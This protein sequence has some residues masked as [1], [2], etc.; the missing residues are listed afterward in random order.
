MDVADTPFV[1]GET[2]EQLLPNLIWVTPTGGAQTTL[3]DALAA[4]AGGTVTEVIVEAGPFLAG[5]DITVSGTVSSSVS[6]TAHGIVIGQG[7]DPVNATAAMDSGQILVGQGTSADPLPKTMSGD[8]TIDNTGALGLVATGVVAD[9][10]GDATHTAQFEVDA[11]GRILTVVNVPIAAPPA[12]KLSGVFTANGTLGTL[13]ADALLLG[14][15]LIETAGHAVDIS[16][17]TSSGGDEVMD[18]TTVGASGIL[19]VPASALS[20]LAF[21]ANQSIFIASASWNGASITANAWYVT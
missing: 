2:F 10:Y 6:P 4:A 8:A 3:A 16:L 9:T 18:A 15:T 12:V 5:A 7:S 21:V 17:G 13:P 20:L 14:V 11:T 1:T 19:P